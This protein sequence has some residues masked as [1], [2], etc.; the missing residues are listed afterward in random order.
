MTTALTSPDAQVE[1]GRAPALELRGVHREHGRG[2]SR[3]QALRGVDL[4]V[5]A[6]ELVAVMGPSGSG[7]STLLALAGGL[8]APTSGEVLVAGTTL[9]GQSPRALAALRRR[10]L[11]Y[12]FQNLNLIPALTAVENVMLPRELDGISARAARR[13]ARAALAEVGVADLADRFPDDMS[14][15]QQQRVAIARALV[16]PRGLVLA[17]EP[18]GALDSH[19]GEAVLRVLRARCDAGSAGLLVTH[20]A[21]HAAWADRVIFLRDGLV[22]DSTGTPATP[23]SL[24]GAPAPFPADGARG[25]ATASPAPDG[26]NPGWDESRGSYEIDES[27]ESEES[28]E[29]GESG[30]SGGSR[31]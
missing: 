26:P 11:G 19:T 16:G 12:V 8:D 30:E 6:G 9:S 13:E 15:G 17:D 14:G 28:D 31:R 10:A 5:R 27:D 4:V 1:V 21:R 7:K 18:T 29:F 22:V 20:E 2:A 3:V 25:D 24:L 23:E